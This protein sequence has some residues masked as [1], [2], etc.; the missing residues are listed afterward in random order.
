MA[1]EQ[2]KETRDWREF[3]F[4][5]TG[6]STEVEQG[7]SAITIQDNLAEELKRLRALADLVGSSHR[8]TDV[9]Y[10]DG[11]ALMLRDIHDRMAEVLDA[12][13]LHERA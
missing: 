8:Q 6:A 5:A 11:L 1:T 12:G 2:E 7:L 10:L 9:K 4:R 3:A 13:R